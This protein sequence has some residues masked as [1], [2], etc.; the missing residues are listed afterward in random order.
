MTAGCG[1]G[2][3]HLASVRTCLTRAGVQLVDADPQLAA[4]GRPEDLVGTALL[5]HYSVAASEQD[6]QALASK[7]DHSGSP[8][9]VS[10]RD[11]IVFSRAMFDA[12]SS[13]INACFA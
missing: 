5:A 12:E 2:A 13:K 7:F 4:A 10:K 6:A 8:N 9:L 3:D 11:V 1:G